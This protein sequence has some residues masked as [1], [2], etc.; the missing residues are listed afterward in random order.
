MRR[1]LGMMWL[2]LVASILVLGLV[3]L[4]DRGRSWER[5]RW[6]V[7]RFEPIL[8]EAPRGERSGTRVVAV[9]PGCPHCLA[10]LAA[11]VGRR[12]ASRDTLGLIALVVD[13]PRRPGEH[14]ARS[15]GVDEVWWDEQGLW[16]RHWG[17]RVYGE[18]YTFDRRGRMVE[19]GHVLSP[20]GEVIAPAKG[21]EGG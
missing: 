14:F 4:A 20:A 21:G 15:L 19:S 18:T 7:A 13:W 16:R 10:G 6:E 5:P 12:D 8:I 11:L 3:W 1:T 2:G 9:H 17:R